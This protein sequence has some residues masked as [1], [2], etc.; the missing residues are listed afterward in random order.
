MIAQ[1]HNDKP[2]EARLLLKKLIQAHL[3]PEVASYYAN[4]NY[5]D[6][7]T[8][9]LEAAQENWQDSAGDNTDQLVASQLDFGQSPSRSVAA[10]ALLDGA[11]E[12][13]AP[14]DLK[15]LDQIRYQ[16]SLAKREYI[17]PCSFNAVSCA[18]NPFRRL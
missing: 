16:A 10:A 5:L 6:T 12:A 14:P 4:N 3:R 17:K 9:Q 13:L 2:L 18:K 15:L 11:T 7:Q 1:A 8:S